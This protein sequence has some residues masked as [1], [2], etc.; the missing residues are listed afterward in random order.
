MDAANT[1]PTSNAKCVELGCL[2]PPYSEKSGKPWHT[3]CDECQKKQPKQEKHMV[4]CSCGQPANPRGLHAKEPKCSAC[5]FANKPQIPVSSTGPA[6]DAVPCG[7]VKC[8]NPPKGSNKHWDNKY[9]CDPC[10][11]LVQ[12]F[13]QTVPVVQKLCSKCGKYPAKSNK[14]HDPK[15]TLCNSCF[16]ESLAQR[17]NTVT[18]AAAAAGSVPVTT[19]FKPKNMTPAAPV[20]KSADPKAGTSVSGLVAAAEK[21]SN[22]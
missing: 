10:Y 1:K 21:R 11:A 7:N 9:Y 6:T 8:K 12:S 17:Q 20:P 5:F 13:A 4:R 19:V 16:S 2:N 3:R 15:H 14:T 22:Q 18:A